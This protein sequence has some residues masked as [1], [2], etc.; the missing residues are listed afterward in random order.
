MKIGNIE[1]DNNVFLA[2]MAGVTDKAFRIIAKECS[3]GFLYTEMVSA[4]GMFYESENTKKLLDIDKREGKCAVQL[5]GNE[6]N[7]LSEIALKLEDYKNDIIDINM[8]CPAPKIVKI[9]DGG[10]LMKNPKLAGEIIKAVSE[11]IKKPVTVKIRKGFYEDENNAVIMAQE[12]EKN[13]AAA[14]AVHGRTV[15]QYYKNNA[16][17]NVIK[18]VKKNVGIPVIGNGDIISPET[19]AEMIEFTGCDAVMIGRAAQG[20]PWIFERTVNYLRTGKLIEE[21]TIEEKI[22]MALRHLELIVEFKGEYIG[23]REMRR[24]M[25]FYIKSMKNSA[26]MRVLLNKAESK[27]EMRRILLDTLINKYVY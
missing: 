13:G 27:E 3:C 10:A 1:T 7:T 18:E 14:I 2:P 23:V 4:K 26:K 21:P 24:H 6:P 15:M 17:W 16:D 22:E 5:F 19:A 12:A 11:K 20:N 9:G 25:G 8:G